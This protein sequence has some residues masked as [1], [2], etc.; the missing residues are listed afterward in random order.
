MSDVG[1]DT[2]L[3][4]LTVTGPPAV[5]VKLSME[6]QPTV[7]TRNRITPVTRWMDGWYREIWCQRMGSKARGQKTLEVKGRGLPSSFCGHKQMMLVAM[8]ME[9]IIVISMTPTPCI[10]AA[11]TW[12]AHLFLFVLSLMLTRNQH[13]SIYHEAKY[14]QARRLSQYGSI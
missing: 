2:L 6:W 5:P 7:G 10:M 8:M 14:S 13:A 1:L 4:E 3:G 12:A 11:R 9:M